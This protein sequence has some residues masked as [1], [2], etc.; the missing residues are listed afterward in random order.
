[1]KKLES[2]RI[3]KE[4]LSSWLLERDLTNQAVSFLN[5]QVDELLEKESK[6]QEQLWPLEDEINTVLVKNYNSQE[7]CDQLKEFVHS[8]PRLG[9][10]ERKLLIESLIAKVLV[11][12]KEVIVTLRP[13]LQSF[14]FIS[15]SIAPRGI[16][17]LFEE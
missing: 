5:T 11:K 6:L 10:G 1:M 16:E 3:K 12:N 17:P 14:G 4:K 15:T 2:L 8:F 9:E 13:P 7:I